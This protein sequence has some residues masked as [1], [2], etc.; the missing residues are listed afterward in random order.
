M[1]SLVDL[2]L[3]PRLTIDNAPEANA[4]LAG[5]RGA[6]GLLAEALLLYDE[7]VLPTHDFGIL[8]AL[9]G[10]LGPLLLR[11]LFERQALRLVRC[12]G[13]VAYAGAGLGLVLTELRNTSQK[14]MPW[15]AEALFCDEAR[16]IEAQ[17]RNALPDLKAGERAALVRLIEEHSERA[18]LDAFFDRAVAKET[19]RDVLNSPDLQRAIHRML[20]PSDLRTLVAVNPTTVS[21]NL[22]RVPGVADDNIR[23]VSPEQL[24]APR[25]PF[26]LL[27]HVADAN[28]SML[29]ASRYD[30]PHIVA[31]DRMAWL[32]EAKLASAGLGADVISGF[33]QILDMERA[34][35]V[36]R[37]VAGGGIDFQDV[38]RL[39]SSGVGQRF[40]R[41]FHSAT[42]SDAQE[43]RRQYVATLHETG[44][45][46]SRSF[47]MLRFLLT[48]AADSFLAGGLPIVGA[49]DSF[50]VDKWL[51]GF[52]PRF[53]IERVY[54]LPEFANRRRRE[55]I[56][57]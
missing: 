4:Q 23:F 36:R 41:W 3:F 26:A 13:V 40:R 42:P 12:R 43:L 38:L 1:S 7:V 6:L 21:L 8:Q 50:F 39:R 44:F 25:D 29:L 49:A 9:S 54:D 32:L 51:K 30:A 53:F 57:V 19:Y 16:A 45:A 28:M 22:K 37:A 47:R 5:N 10:W 20:S 17:L 34:P 14:Q 52:S 24:S 48:S 11:E 46:R 27:F 33:S 18:S 55:R 31:S 35:D 56:R 2:R 15:W